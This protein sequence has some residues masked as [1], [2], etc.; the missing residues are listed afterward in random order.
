MAPPAGFLNKNKNRILGSLRG[1]C[2]RLYICNSLSRKPDP[3]AGAFID[4][5]ASYIKASAIGP[6]LQDNMVSRI[7]L[8]LC[9]L[10]DFSPRLSGKVFVIVESSMFIFRYVEITCTSTARIIC[11]DYGRVMVLEVWY[12]YLSL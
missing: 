8:F 2:G 6:G 12:I 4:R 9:V 11:D 5:S 7:C 1:A 10:F 3:L